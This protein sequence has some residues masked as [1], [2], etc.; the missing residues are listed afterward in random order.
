MANKAKSLDLERATAQLER[1]LGPGASA[2]LSNS[3]H[4]VI[5]TPGGNLEC[6]LHLVLWRQPSNAESQRSTV[7]VLQRPSRNARK[8]L[9]ARGEN[10]IDLERGDIRIHMPQLILDRVGVRVPRR[11]RN[12]RPLINPFGDRASLVS[13]ALASEPG[14]IWTTR[15]LAEAAGVSS[16]TSSHVVR[17][18]EGAGVLVVE[19][20]GRAN[21][22]YLKSV[23]ALI[24]EWA[25]HY[26]WS[27][28]RWK[29]FAAPVGDTHRF[30]PRLPQ[31]LGSRKWALTLQA[32]ADLVAPIAAFSKIHVYVDVPITEI[33]RL[34][35]DQ[36][37]SEA[38]DGRLALCRPYYKESAWSGLHSVRNLPV[39]SDV[40]LA[41]DLWDYPDRG[42]EAAV[43]LLETSS[44]EV[45]ER[46]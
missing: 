24:V 9:R 34:A 36:G 40:Q 20:H 3:N 23:R 39:V 8:I 35:R 16:M 46:A 29:S 22:I 38:S 18:L 42:R 31:L 6:R 37:W 26:D 11:S 17:Q 28:N 19:S 25:R 33:L 45:F 5:R 27:T 13:R 43:H 44:T 4:V 30:V 2:T 14:R 1:A 7:W 10:F 32:G 12:D 21:R 41:I 15:S